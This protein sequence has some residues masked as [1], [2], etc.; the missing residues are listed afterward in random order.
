MRRFRITVENLHEQPMNVTVLD[1]IPY[2]EDEK[3]SP[4]GLSGKLLK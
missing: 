2:S 4:P 1:R 3:R